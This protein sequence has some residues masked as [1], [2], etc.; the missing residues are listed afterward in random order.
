[1]LSH[2]YSFFSFNSL[3]LLNDPDK[4][5]KTVLGLGGK[6]YQSF[7]TKIDGG[8][9]RYN[10]RN[11]SYYPLSNTTLLTFECKILRFVWEKNV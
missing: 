1:M 6:P 8:F 2:L 4:I 10:R 7:K 9:C 5:L 3:I 11:K